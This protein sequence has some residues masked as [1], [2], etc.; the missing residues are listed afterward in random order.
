MPHAS[1]V[2]HIPRTTT[3]RLHTYYTDHIHISP[4]S[5]S[6]TYIYTTQSH[7]IQITHTHIFHTNMPHKNLKYA[8]QIHTT[9]CYILPHTHH[10]YTHHSTIHTSHIFH[11]RYTYITF[12][13]HKDTIYIEHIAYTH[14]H[15]SIVL[16]IKAEQLG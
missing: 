9:H 14:T 6:A 7:Q 16:I 8:Y 3:H 11:T 2:S 13:L 1:H 12:I 15:C 10:T 5:H 4:I